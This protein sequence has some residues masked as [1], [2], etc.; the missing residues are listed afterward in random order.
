MKKRAPFILLLFVLFSLNSCIKE[1]VE[2][3]LPRWFLKRVW[4]M[5]SLKLNGVEVPDTMAKYFNEYKFQY[6][7]YCDPLFRC[8]YGFFYSR[9]GHEASN[10][11][12]H[13]PSIELFVGGIVSAYQFCY[14]GPHTY[15][16]YPI[17][18]LQSLKI[19]KINKDEIHLVSNVPSAEMYEVV[20]KSEVK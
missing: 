17:P 19:T 2:H 9:N 10:N 14:I 18:S 15:Y 7:E 20:F 8:N 16:P 3:P 4:S 1:K 6:E 11:L 12:Y 13:R 5:T